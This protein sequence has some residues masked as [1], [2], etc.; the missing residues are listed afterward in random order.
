VLCSFIP[1]GVQDAYFRL[2]VSVLR[3]GPICVVIGYSFEG[4][5]ER[6]FGVRWQVASWRGA[7]SVGTQ[8]ESASIKVCE[9]GAAVWAHRRLRSV[10]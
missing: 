6:K 8:S 3:L 4:G 2:H 7:W 10:P 1:A 9:V 5:G